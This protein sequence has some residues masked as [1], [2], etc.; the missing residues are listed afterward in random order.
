MSTAQSGGL[1]DGL[2]TAMMVM[3]PERSIALAQR[4]ANVEALIVAKSGAHFIT[5]GF[6][7]V[8]CVAGE[9]N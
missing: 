9:E 2:S 6:P 7:L 5:A 1:A 8:S 4:L 3:G